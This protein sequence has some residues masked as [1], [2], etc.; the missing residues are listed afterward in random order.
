MQRFD[1]RLEKKTRRVLIGTAVELTVASKYGG[2]CIFH[3]QYTYVVRIRRDEQQ[4][5]NT[6]RWEQQNSNDLRINS[7]ND[8]VGNN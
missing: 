5:I 2:I 6:N 1:D 3:V 7:G 8:W 4:W